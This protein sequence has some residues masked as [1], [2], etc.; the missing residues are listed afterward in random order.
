MLSMIKFGADEIFKSKDSSITD[1]DIDLI[2]SKG[3]KKTAELNEKF[4]KNV[5]NLGTF[6]LDGGNKLLKKVLI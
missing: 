3:E 6:S 4:Q 1:E 2:I 5:L